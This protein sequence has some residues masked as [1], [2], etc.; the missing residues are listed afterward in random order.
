MVLVVEVYKAVLA[1]LKHYNTTSMTPDEF[2]YHIW[3]ATLEYVKNRYW[4][5]LLYMLDKAPKQLVFRI[6]FYICMIFCI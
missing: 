6:L 5:Q 1:E 3:I 4:A 2:N